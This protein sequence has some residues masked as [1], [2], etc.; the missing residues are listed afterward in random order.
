MQYNIIAYIFYKNIC[1]R[2]HDIY[3][4]IYIY[5]H[6]YKPDRI[7]CHINNIMMLDDCDVAFTAQ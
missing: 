6:V 1:T 4:Y 5:I 2:T 7:E 3:I